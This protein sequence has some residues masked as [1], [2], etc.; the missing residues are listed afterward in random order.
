MKGGA[1]V[2]LEKQI[3]EIYTVG[4]QLDGGPIA[5]NTLST[6]ASDTNH[7]YNS[8]TDDALKASFQDIALKIMSLYLSQ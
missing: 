3:I 6:C 8:A 7:F 1:N 2:P 5:V 4:F